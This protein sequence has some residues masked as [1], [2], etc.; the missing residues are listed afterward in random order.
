MPG[1]FTPTEVLTAWEAGADIV[2]VF[3]A[4]VVGPAF[5]KALRGPLPQVKLMPTGGV[6]LTTAAEFLKA[7]RG[8]PGRR[9]AAGRP[10]GRRGRRLRPDHGTGEAVRRDRASKAPQAGDVAPCPT[11]SPSARRWSGSRRRTS[12][13]SNRPASLDVEIGG[14]ELNTAVGP[15]A[16]RPLGRVGVAAARQPARQ[17]HRQPRP[18]GRRLAT[19]FVQYDPDARCGLYFLEF[20]ASP[21]A[22][23]ILYDRK[24]SAI[25]RVTRGMFDW[26][27]IFAGAK[28]FHVTGITAALSPGAAEAV[29]EAMR[30]AKAAGRDDERR[31]QLPLEALEPRATPP[32]VMGS[33]LP[34][35]DVLIASEADAEFLFG[36]TGNDFTEVAEG[37]VE[38]FGVKT[39]VG[40]RREADW[41]GGTASRRSATRPGRRTNPRG[42]RWRSWTGS[43]PA[44]RSPPG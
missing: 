11:S 15:G 13:G 35:C 44:T 6:D 2:K 22:S 25:A 41:S 24:D 32:Q 29:D 1:A 12:S 3:P 30:A 31:S 4:D 21:R 39:V 9:R 14:A 23:S 20:G 36:I 37:L 27:A 16:A 5:F 10:E 42:T 43:G 8:V 18:R 7:G 28:W 40:T 38:K 34:L 33:L 26:P 19:E 17:A